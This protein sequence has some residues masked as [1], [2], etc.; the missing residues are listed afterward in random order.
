MLWW[1]FYIVIP[2]ALLATWVYMG[3]RFARRI[4]GITF[5]ILEILHH[6]VGTEL[7]SG[8]EL[9]FELKKRGHRLSQAAFCELAYRLTK[10][11]VLTR[12]DIEGGIGSGGFQVKIACYDAGPAGVELYE[13]EMALAVVD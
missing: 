10:K 6:Q 11:G 7:P 9:R 12:T 3:I 8:P 13:R 2:I 4:K 1:L 5:L